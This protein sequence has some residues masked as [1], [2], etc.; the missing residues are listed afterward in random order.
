[1]DKNAI[2]PS[3]LRFLRDC[4]DDVTDLTFAFQAASIEETLETFEEEVSAVRRLLNS[5]LEAGLI[6]PGSWRADVVGLDFWPGDTDELRRRVSES[7]DA[8][9]SRPSPAHPLWFGATK[10]G[11]DLVEAADRTT[12]AS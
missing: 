9:T 11:Q 2:A 8:L 5:L 4:V 1:M 7:L 12:G 6:R 10:A 3:S